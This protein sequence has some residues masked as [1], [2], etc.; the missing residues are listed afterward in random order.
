MSGQSP[1]PRTGTGVVHPTGEESPLTYAL[2]L[3]GDKVTVPEFRIEDTDDMLRAF[4]DDRVAVVSACAGSLDR[5]CTARSSASEGKSAVAAGPA[6]GAA[7]T[8]RALARSSY[9]GGP[10]AVLGPRWRR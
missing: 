6:H 4:G 5:E 10:C 8:A 2:H 3:V 1:G 7:V 9:C